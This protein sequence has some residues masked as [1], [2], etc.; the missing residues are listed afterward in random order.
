MMKTDY[1]KLLI[2]SL[3]V[4][5]VAADIHIF[6]SPNNFAFGG[7][8]GLS[9]VL[10][11]IQPF[12]GLGE[13]MLILNALLLV[14]GFL[15][16]GKGFGGKTVYCTLLLSALVWLLG[17][18]FPMNG[19]LTGN[20][21]LEFL[22]AVFLPGAGNAVVFYAGGTTGGT[23]IIAKIITKYTNLKIGTALIA[24]DFTVVLAA[25]AAYGAE[26]FLFAVAGVIMKSFAVDLMLESFKVFK[27]I[28]IVSDKS[29]D[30]KRFIFEKLNRGA[31]AHIARGAFTD[32]EKEVVTTV[33]SRREALKLQAFVKNT[34]PGA[35]ITISNSSHI[36]G[37]G[38]TRVE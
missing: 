20:K 27:I 5:I 33:L 31:T 30:I 25:G 14:V 24:A 9:I 22:Y 34:D 3:G 1:K 10:A 13:I 2:M 19:T 11:K 23:D 35:F 16:L 26:T 37:N 6:K 17:N 7:V 8:S 28:V 15:V 4:F 21:M 32:T 12:I 36:I 18:F 38:F 29:E